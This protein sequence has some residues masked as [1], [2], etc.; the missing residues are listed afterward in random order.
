M[1]KPSIFSKFKLKPY[2]LE[3]NPEWL[4][5]SSDSGEEPLLE[6][7]I[8]EKEDKYYLVLNKRYGI[9]PSENEH[10]LVKAKFEEYQESAK[11]FFS[12][13]D[14]VSVQTGF[15]RVEILLRM[16]EDLSDLEAEIGEKM[17]T[18][19]KKTSLELNTEL[20]DIKK[21]LKEESKGITEVVKPHIEQLNLFSS[22]YEETM[23]NYY[24]SLI[25]YFLSGKRMLVEI[26]EKTI[27]PVKV[28]FDFENVKNLH[29]DFQRALIKFVNNELARWS[30][31]EGGKN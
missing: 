8:T 21:K 28:S 9:H 19:E 7:I 13:L 23:N 29:L 16:P 30:N 12:Y 15:T 14:N 3:I 20:R 24:I 17:A 5:F 31:E 27:E 11:K 26:D 22:E 10:I 6:K 25:A 18:Q 2:Y 4:M 1:A